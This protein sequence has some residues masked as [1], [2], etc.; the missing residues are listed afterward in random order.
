MLSL[1]NIH[2]G[3]IMYHIETTQNNCVWQIW[4]NL[5]FITGLFI[6]ARNFLR[7][8]TLTSNKFHELIPKIFIRFNPKRVAY[9]LNIHLWNVHFVSSEKFYNVAQTRPTI[10]NGIRRRYT[11]IRSL[12]Y[13]YFLKHPSFILSDAIKAPLDKKATPIHSRC[14][15]A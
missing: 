10:H 15:D 6:N 5:D 14:P 11:F 2:F 9:K 13:C 1:Y 12:F 8:D 3:L 4:K 7:I